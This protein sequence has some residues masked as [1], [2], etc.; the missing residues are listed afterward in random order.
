MTFFTVQT[1]ATGVLGSELWQA[2]SQDWRALTWIGLLQVAF[3]LAAWLAARTLVPRREMNSFGQYDRRDG[4]GFGKALLLYLGSLLLAALAF[5]VLRATS[6]NCKLA[7][8]TLFSHPT[9]LEAK[10]IA[11]FALCAPV[12]LAI[13]LGLPM[14]IFRV[15]ILRA[16]VLVVFIKLLV[17]GAGWGLD[18][19]LGRPVEKCMFIVRE[20]AAQ[21]GGDTGLLTTLAARAEVEVVFTATEKVGADSSK[22]MRERKDAIRSLFTQLEEMRTRLPQ[23]DETALEDYNA[24]KA[25]YEALLQQVRKDI[26]AHPELA[27]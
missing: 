11:I 8:L 15:R 9:H 6:T 17:L 19:L 26:L 18:R 5:V 22:P 21:R 1:V 25:R 14:L 2:I 20:W 12:V 27:E 10:W 7:L 23:G 24:K 13:G 3:L 4:A 16:F